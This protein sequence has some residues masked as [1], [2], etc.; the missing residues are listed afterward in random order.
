M[1]GWTRIVGNARFRFASGGNLSSYTSEQKLNF[2]GTCEGSSCVQTPSCGDEH[3]DQ[4]STQT[5]I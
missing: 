5:L 1:Q 4:R 2:Q 3:E